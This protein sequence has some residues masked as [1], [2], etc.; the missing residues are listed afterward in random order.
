MNIYFGILLDKEI[1]YFYRVFG[2]LGFNCGFLFLLR[3]WKVLIKV[4]D[5]YILFLIFYNL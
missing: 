3:F 1:F 2:Y 4:F 5:I